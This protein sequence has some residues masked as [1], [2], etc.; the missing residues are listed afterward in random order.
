M[1]KRAG[2]RSARLVS[3]GGDPSAT[4]RQ[5]AAGQRAPRDHAHAVSAATGSTSASM[6]RTSI[7]YGGCSH[8]EP[9][10]PAP[11]RRSTAPRRSRGRGR[12]SC[13]GSAPCPA[14]RGRSSAPS[15]SSIGGVRL[16]PV[17]LV[18]VDP[19]GAEPAQAVLDGAHDPAA[20][21]AAV[22]CGPRPSARGTWSPARRRRGGRAGPCRRSPRTPPAAYT[23]A[24]STKLMP[25]SSARWMM[26]IDS[27]WSRLPARPNIIVPRQS[28]LTSTPVCPSGRYRM[29]AGY[30][31]FGVTPAT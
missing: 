11:L 4:A 20:G 23:S 6:P 17:H 16:G 18:E 29:A 25:A 28:V 30:R 8:D 10:A 19:V 21:V 22:G 12:S 2:I 14:R 27:S 26:R 15:V 13:R 3:G 5:P 31:R 1:S 24:V 9:I 7:E